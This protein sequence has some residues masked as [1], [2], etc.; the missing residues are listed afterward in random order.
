M[1]ERRERQQQRILVLMLL[2][3]FLV[4]VVLAATVRAWGAPGDSE[5]DPLTTGF[6]ALPL[7]YRCPDQPH[8]AQTCEPGKWYF[9][10][11]IGDDDFDDW[12]LAHA[13]SD[14]WQAKYD[15]RNELL[16]TTKN[17]MQVQIDAYA[18]RVIDLE[19]ELLRNSRVLKWNATVAFIAGSVVFTALTVAITAI[20]YE[21][22]MDV[23]TNTE[24]LFLKDNSR[25]VWSLP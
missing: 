13:S 11:L 2:A 25:R 5:A 12:I 23:G 10:T 3:A 14:K 15:A 24:G 6:E 4:A 16:E 17:L 21:I 20:V 19:A 8:E 1:D 22:R 18:K 9:G 7:A